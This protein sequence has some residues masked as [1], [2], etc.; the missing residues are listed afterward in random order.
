MFEKE[1]FDKAIKKLTQ[2]GTTRPDPEDHI[3]NIIRATENTEMGDEEWCNFYMYIT[4]QHKEEFKYLPRSEMIT[5]G[6]LGDEELNRI[7]EEIGVGK[8]STIECVQNGFETHMRVSNVIPI[9]IKENNGK[10]QL[11]DP[12]C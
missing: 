5:L 11:D 6:D 2:L 3:Y 4:C 7:Q 9:T 12:R 8:H 1:N 10:K